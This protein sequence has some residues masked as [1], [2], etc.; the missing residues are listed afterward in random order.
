M[1]VSLILDERILKTTSVSAENGA[2]K[3]TGVLPNSY[4]V[5]I[6]EDGKCW[7]EPVKKVSVSEDVKNIVFKQIGHIISV[8]ST[9]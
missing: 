5:S 8:S 1:E 3:F 7:E 9:R 2:Y 4:T 6:S